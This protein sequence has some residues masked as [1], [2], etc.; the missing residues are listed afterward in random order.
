MSQAEDGHTVK[1]HYTGTLE[2]GT[3]FDSSLGGE[4]LEFTIG[5]GQVISGFDDAC[6][7]M[8]TGEK[9][10]V[11]LPPEEAYGER[12]PELTGTIDRSMIH[13]DVQLEIG[14]MLTDKTPDGEQVHVVVTSFDDEKVMIDGNPPL[15]GATLTFEIEMV[16][17]A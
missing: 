2:D 10:S 15:A 7:G 12:N 11:T 9:K 1:I 5:S 17:I 3:Q 8:A 6:R 14:M 16:E 13:Q 4:P